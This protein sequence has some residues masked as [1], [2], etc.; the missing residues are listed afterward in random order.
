[1]RAALIV[2]LGIGMGLTPVSSCAAAKDSCLQVML[3]R[4]YSAQESLMLKVNQCEQNRAL[5][6]AGLKDG[7]GRTTDSLRKKRHMSR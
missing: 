3:K 7:R 2:T 1:M 5:R 4:G 6:A